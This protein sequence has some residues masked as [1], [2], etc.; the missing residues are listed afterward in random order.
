MSLKLSLFRS[1]TDTEPQTQETSWR[2]LIAD[3]GPHTTYYTDKFSVPAF[4]PATFRGTRTARNVEEIH[5]GVLDLDSISLSDLDDLCLRVEGYRYILYSTWSHRPDRPCARLLIPFDRPVKPS[6]WSNVWQRLHTEFGGYGDPSCKDLSRLYFVPSCLQSELK[7]AFY[8]SEIEGKSFFV[9]SDS[10]EVKALNMIAGGWKRAK[11][12]HKQKLGNALSKAIQGE[13]FAEEGERDTTLFQIITAIVDQKPNID[14]EGLAEHFKTSLSKMGAD[15]PTFDQTV[16]KIN[17]HKKKKE[18]L[19][20]QLPMPEGRSGP[21][22]KEEL[23]GF[24]KKQKTTP[25]QFPW[26]IQQ[27][28]AYYVFFNGTYLGPYVESEIVPVVKKYLQPVAPHV[29][30]MKMGAKN[31]VFKR[32]QELVIE[33]GDIAKKIIADLTATHASYDPITEIITEAPCPLDQTLEPTHDLEV[34]QWLQLLA[35]DE[36][37]TLV[38]WLSAV[39]DLTEP[40]AALYLDGP[41]GAGKTLLADGLARLWGQTPSN[42]EHALDKFNSQLVRCPLVLADEMIPTDWKGRART[43]E[44][45]QFIQNRSHVIN[46][47]FLPE[48]EAKGSTRLILT[49]NNRELLTNNDNLTVNDIKAITNRLIYIQCSSKASKYL[50]SLGPDFV[51]SFVSENRIAKHT[52]YL[53][54]I[55]EIN[56]GSRFLVEGADSRLLRTLTTMTGLRSAVCCWLVSYLLSPSRYESR[57]DKLVR[58]F[59]GQVCANVRGL[60]KNWRIYEAE[61]RIPKTNQ[62]SAALSGI[63]DGRRKLTAGNGDRIQYHTID[64]ENLL[65]WAEESGYATR[66]ILEKALTRES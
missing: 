24:A 51:H 56:R 16:D 42:L 3:L 35:G 38:Q 47:K 15:A 49:S 21:Y 33:Y 61:D 29:Q 50:S 12:E 22:S 48:V 55:T 23:E 6:D 36:Y 60:A 53:Q 17:R 9:A 19:P 57:G 54:S 7:H 31:L 4:S 28:K 40:C 52:L 2:Q 1:I 10:V 32:P 63:A 34:E 39:T 8:F 59:G 58:T 66:E 18:T 11:S 5:F 26:I 46:R 14:A 45:R 43:A 13:P 30:V 25:E 20:L 41:P 37:E 64:S 62:L 44:L 27:T 65:C